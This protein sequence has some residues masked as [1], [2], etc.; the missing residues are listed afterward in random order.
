MTLPRHLSTPLLALQPAPWTADALCA[1]HPNPDL[2]FAHN[3]PGHTGSLSNDQKKAIAI[4]RQC[5]VR[6]P[7]LVEA[8]KTNSEGV[9]GGTTHNQRKRLRIQQLRKG[10]KQQ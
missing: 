9:W 1:T 2:W 5:P 3:K 7:C 4:C 6:L 10:E 8:I